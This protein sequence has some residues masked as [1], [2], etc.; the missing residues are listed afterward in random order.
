MIKNML[1]R[2]LQKRHANITGTRNAITLL[3]DAGNIS[4]IFGGFVHRL[5]VRIPR[6]NSI[7]QQQTGFRPVF[8]FALLLLF[9]IAALMLLSS[10]PEIKTLPERVIQT[11][12]L[13]FFP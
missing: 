3:A 10:T 2:I 12:P 4:G 5:Q 6:S 13:D 7:S 11:A 8:F 9:I 1:T